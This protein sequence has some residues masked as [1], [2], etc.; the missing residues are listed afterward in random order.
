MA[1]IPI[2]DISPFLTP[3]ITNDANNDTSSLPEPSPDQISTAK[4]LYH[5][6]STWGFCLLKNHNVPTQ[7]QHDIYAS[8]K[9]FYD[10]PLDEKLKLHVKKGGVAWRG[11]MPRGGERTHGSTDHKEGM[12]F[13]PEHAETH[14]HAGLPL[15]CAYI[16]SQTFR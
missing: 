9:S 4:A 1:G 15:V 13:G 11:Y 3:A 7:L 6:F 2:I 16:A 12:Y 5:T 8:M 10:L 14:I